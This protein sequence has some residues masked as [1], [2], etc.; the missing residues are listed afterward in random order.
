MEAEAVEGEAETLTGG[1]VVSRYVVCD[2]LVRKDVLQ[3]L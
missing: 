1:R 3:S 2:G